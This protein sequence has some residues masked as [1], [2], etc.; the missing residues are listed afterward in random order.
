MTDPQFEGDPIEDLL[1][2]GAVLATRLA[3]GEW[4]RL[5]PATPLLRGGIVFIF[6]AGSFISSARQQLIDLA[7][8]APQ[9]HDA[10]DPVIF[11]TANGRLPIALL[12]IALVQIG[13]AHG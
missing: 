1:P 7:F 12:A 3:D 10:G 6:I 8:G 2:P 11:L 4:H 13:R 9:A 5:H